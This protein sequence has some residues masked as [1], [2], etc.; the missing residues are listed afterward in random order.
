ME[1]HEILDTISDR[2]LVKRVQTGDREAYEVLINRYYRLIYGICFGIVSNPHDSQDLCQDVLMQG[3]VNIC[4][5]RSGDRFGYWLAGIARNRCLDWLRRQSR[6]RLS[7]SH[8]AERIDTDTNDD[9]KSEVTEA[10]AQ[11][12][13]ELRVPLTMYYLDGQNCRAISKILGISHASV[14]RRLK[15]AKQQMYQLLKGADHEI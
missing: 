5:L 13:M 1:R 10:V 12:P 14:W 15:S 6:M 4:S 9:L 11:L 3:Y 7:T 2:S 8:L